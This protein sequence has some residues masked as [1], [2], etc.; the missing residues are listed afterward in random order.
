MRT[1]SLAS[2]QSCHS[3][4]SD[5]WCSQTLTLTD[6]RAVA[7]SR[8][9]PFVLCVIL[10]DSRNI[11]PPPWY[12][13]RSSGK[14]QEIWLILEAKVNTFKNMWDREGDQDQWFPMYDAEMFT[15]VRDKDRDQYPLFPNV[16]VSFPL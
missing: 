12:V 7:Y 2:S 3:T 4:D 5:A 9:I 8:G 1:V 13:L 6:H 15:P 11:D 14:T 10:T 16:P